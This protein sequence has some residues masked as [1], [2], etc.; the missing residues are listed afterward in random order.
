MCVVCR[1][2]H[3]IIGILLPKEGQA[4]WPHRPL[5]PAIGSAARTAQIVRGS[6]FLQK[7]PRTLVKSSRSPGL[8]L[9]FFFKKALELYR[10]QPSIHLM[11]EQE[12][13]EQGGAALHR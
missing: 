1:C 8:L 12:K 9:V 2:L 10:N 13:S 7:K 4:A 5:F 6:V 11:E 3:L